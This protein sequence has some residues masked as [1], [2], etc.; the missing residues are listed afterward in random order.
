[1]TRATGSS[2]TIRIFIFVTLLWLCQA[3]ERQQR[4]FKATNLVLKSFHCFLHRTEVVGTTDHFDL[5]RGISGRSRADTSQRALQ[6]VRCLANLPAIVLIDR[7]VNLSERLWILLHE[8]V[9]NAPEESHVSAH[10]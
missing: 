9:N 1:M 4:I 6:P 2:S 8:H 5:Q 3:S 7:S 10:T